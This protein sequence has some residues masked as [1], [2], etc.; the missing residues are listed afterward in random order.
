MLAPMAFL[1]TGLLGACQENTP[2]NTNYPSATS[3]MGNLSATVVS[4]DGTPIAGAAVT[5]KN[6]TAKEPIPDIAHVSDNDGKLIWNSLPVGD[7]TFTVSAQGY[8]NKEVAVSIESGQTA[9]E[10]VTLE[11][12]PSA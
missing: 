9:T 1:G 5:V 11:A 8:K 4:Q 12:E 2:T 3:A 10:T 6:T 7:Y